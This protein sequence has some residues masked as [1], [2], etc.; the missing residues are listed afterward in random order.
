MKYVFAFLLCFAS[1][2]LFAQNDDAELFQ[3]IKAK[4][5]LLFN[6]GFNNC[7]IKQFVELVSEDFEFYHDEAG[8]MQS[9]K[10]FIE[11]VENGICKLNYKSRRELVAGSVAVYPLKNKGVLYGAV[12]TGEHRFYALEKD[13]SEHLTS[14][15][16]FTHVWLIE[17]GA[18]KLSRALS[19]D[20]RVPKE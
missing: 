9:K 18:W 2:E 16:K 5:S 20:H 8:T 1:T 3:T 15:A 4:D 6:L 13:G 11:S 7:D 12:Q 14:E 10:E 19:F 17:A